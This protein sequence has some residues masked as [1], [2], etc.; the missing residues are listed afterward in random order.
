MR[1]GIGE[2]RFFTK[3][4][5]TILLGRKARNISEL[6]EGIKSVPGSSIYY[7]T[8]RFLQQHHYLSPEPPN[9]FSYW[10]I[11][12]L[13]ED[14]LGEMISSIDTV[15]YKTIADLR[16]TLIEVISSYLQMSSRS[17]DAPSGEEFYFMSLQ[18]FVLPTSH[19]AQTVE[20]FKEQLQAITIHSLYYHI[21]DA[22]LRLEQGEND[23]SAWFRGMGKPELADALL[24]LDPYTSTLETLRTKII[25]LV[26]KYDRN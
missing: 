10:I 7:H 19:I 16:K 11:N 2:F 5:Q 15:Q 20:E 4:D 6:L 25:T 12:V 14:H 22:H 26:S 3:I 8:H 23:F 9:D 17:V 21:F 18:T 1:Q 24:H 13:N